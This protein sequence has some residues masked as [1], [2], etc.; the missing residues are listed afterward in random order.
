M[1][2]FLRKK[3]IAKRVLW[4]LAIII[5][6]AFVLWGAG[7]LLEKKSSIKYIGAIDGQKIHVDEFIKS[8]RD[9]QIGLFLNYFNQPEALKKIQEDR[10]LL[11]RLAWENLLLNKGAKKANVKVSD[12]EVVNFVT[13]FPLFVRGG[14]FDE[15][16][17]NY[18]LRNSLGI[19]PRSFE[20]SIR[21][22]LINAKYK[23]DIIKSVTA[24]DEE[25]R[26]AYKNEF[27]KAKIY[28]VL[29]DKDDFKK[30]V[31]VSKNEATAFYEKNK[32][33]FVDPEKV[34][35][36]YIAFPHKEENAK[37]KALENLKTAYEKIKKRPGDFEKI[38]ADSGYA[39]QETSPFSQDEVVAGLEMAKDINIVSFRLRPM[40]DVLPMLNENEIGTSYIMRVKEKLSSGI[41]PEENVSSYIVDVLKDEK[42]LELSGSEAEKIYEDAAG[43]NAPLR[44]LAEKY[45]LQV[46]ES[47]PI[48]RFDYLEGIGESFNVVNSA[49]SLKIGQIS[50]PIRVR[51][52]FALIEPVKFEPIDEEKFEKEKADYSNKV[53]AIKKMKALES[54]FGG[55]RANSSLN[56]DLDKI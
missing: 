7:S 44:E 38:A 10:K 29:I 41:K 33:L 40:I 13:N 46:R 8:V 21:A 27:E 2:N 39:V 26:K 43:S 30:Y 49:F 36:Q 56:V 23:A 48:S 51:K 50:K 3:K 22:F 45:G 31:E 34:V 17:Y 12:K 19:T 35:V 54:W 42:A 37:E 1:L 9:V 5:I 24:S 15:K 52:G 11:N 20:E 55:V 28:Y 6:P 25:I 14:A 18:I 47:E 16:L 32:K 4:F 53:L